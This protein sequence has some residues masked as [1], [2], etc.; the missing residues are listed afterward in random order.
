MAPAGEAVAA[1]M[2]ATPQASEDAAAVMAAA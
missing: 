2:A 1:V